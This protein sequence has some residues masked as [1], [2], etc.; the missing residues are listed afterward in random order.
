MY[1]QD[2]KKSNVVIVKWYFDV[3]DNSRVSPDC[4]FVWQSLSDNAVF[5]KLLACQ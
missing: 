5:K 3:W 4:H 2:T 1:V